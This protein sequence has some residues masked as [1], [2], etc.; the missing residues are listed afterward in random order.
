MIQ[1]VSLRLIAL[2]IGI[3][4]V[5]SATFLTYVGKISPEQYM[6]IVSSV[7]T[8]VATLGGTI[9]YDYARRAEKTKLDN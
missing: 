8:L 9:V 1:D 6:Q 7:L 5:V 3:V 4:L 2:V